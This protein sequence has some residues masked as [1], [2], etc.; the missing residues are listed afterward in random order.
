MLLCYCFSDDIKLSTFLLPVF[1][2][3]QADSDV[4]KLRS[5]DHELNFNKSKC[6]ALPLGM[7]PQAPQFLGN[8]E[9]KK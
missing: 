3:M 7:K 4:P 2:N 1:S 9:S 8:N 5:A 6:V